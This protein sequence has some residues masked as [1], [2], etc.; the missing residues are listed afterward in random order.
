MEKKNDDVR[1]NFHRKINRWDACGSLLKIEQRQE[2]LAPHQREKRSYQKQNAD[3][4][5]H[6][7]KQAAAA[8]F[9]RISTIQNEQ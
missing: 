2:M 8:K 7:G 1:K 5:E 3:H 6:G 9:P 4:W